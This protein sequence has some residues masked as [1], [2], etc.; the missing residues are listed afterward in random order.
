MLA[1]QHPAT[2]RIESQ[3]FGKDCVILRIVRMN[4]GGQL[5]DQGQIGDRHGPPPV[6]GGGWGV[7]GHAGPVA[8][9]G[10][11]FLPDI[12]PP[13]GERPDR[14]ND[15]MRGKSGMGLFMRGIMQ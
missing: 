4:A 7:R 9:F 14:H 2:F 13:C 6:S 15:R 10:T 3:P 8:R 5:V 1:L 11:A 12:S